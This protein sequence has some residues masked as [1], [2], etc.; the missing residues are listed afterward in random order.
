[1]EEF[2]RIFGT[3]IDQGSNFC[4]R[5]SKFLQYTQHIDKPNIK[6]QC[7]L[8]PVVIKGR[9]NQSK[10]Y[11]P[12]LPIVF[13]LTNSRPECQHDNT[14]TFNSIISRLQIRDPNYSFIELK[15][16]EYT[17]TKIT[18]LNYL[19]SYFQFSKLG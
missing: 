4:C 1:M 5:Q 13:A 8:N 7:R 10:N 19:I 3:Q 2:T 14:T 6:E 12:F 11:L 17:I 16:M 18:M 9:E 15:K